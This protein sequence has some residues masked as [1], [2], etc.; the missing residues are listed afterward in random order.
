MSYL[1][2]ILAS[3]AALRLLRNVL[4]WTK[5]EY[6]KSYWKLATESESPG[7]VAKL[8]TCLRTE[9]NFPR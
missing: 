9:C 2:R 5:A 7:N 6:P 4:D 3:P 8:E 1:R